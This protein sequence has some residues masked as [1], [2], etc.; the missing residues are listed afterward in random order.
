M[1]NHYHLI[2]L[3]NNVSG[4]EDLVAEHGL[5]IYISGGEKRVLFDTGDTGRFI[6]NA[7]TLGVD[8]NQVD[9]LVFSHGHY[10]HVGGSRSFF[11]EFPAPQEVYAG[12]NFFQKQ[13]NRDSQG[14]LRYIGNTYHEGWFMDQGIHFYQL[15]QDKFQLAPGMWLVTNFPQTNDFEPY[16]PFSEQELALVLETEKGLVAV[17]G[18]SHIGVVNICTEIQRRFGTSLYGFIGGTHLKVADE[19]RI[20]KTSEWFAQSKIQLL[21]ACHCSGEKAGELFGKQL[22]HYYVNAVGTE[23]CL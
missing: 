21:G 12:M 20:Q 5:S 10:D 9:V 6:D 8:L 3:I 1:M 11:R 16:Y 2:T 7:K 17:C 13:S 23:T 18:C 14:R 4:R 15:D 22:E 19:E